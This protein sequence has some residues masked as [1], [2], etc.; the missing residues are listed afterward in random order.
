MGKREVK[1][2]AFKAPEDWYEMVKV[3]ARERHSTNSSAIIRL[4][5]LGVQMY[6]IVKESERS[7]ITETLDTLSRSKENRSQMISYG[8][9]M[10]RQK[11]KEAH[12]APTT[13][14]RGSGK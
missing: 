2:N 8:E 14:K 7:A 9:I 12:E 3:I 13:T 10:R 6:G 5:Y 1:V 11:S 4:V